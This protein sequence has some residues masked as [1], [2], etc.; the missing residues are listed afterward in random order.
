M[1]EFDRRRILVTGASSGIGYATVQRLA[2]TGA[3]V[4]AHYNSNAAG[5]RAAIADFADGFAHLVGGD[6]ANPGG[7]DAVWTAAARNVQIYLIAPGGC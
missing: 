4:I 5:A 7:A 1:S 3:R 2:G 6:L